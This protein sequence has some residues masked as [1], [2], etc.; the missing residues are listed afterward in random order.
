MELIEPSV[1]YGT[2]Y[3]EALQEYLRT[4]VGDGAP[5]FIEEIGSPSTVEEYIQLRRDHAKGKR[6]PDGWIPN[7]TYWLVD[8]RTFLGEVNLRHELTD[9]LRRIGGHIGYWISPFQRKKGYGKEILK[10]VLE[11]AKA[12]DFKKVLITCDES[13]EASIKIIESNGG[14]FEKNEHVAEGKP[15]K[16]LYW[17]SL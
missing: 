12:R 1:Q 16:H 17:I 6:L 13:N 3:W 14:V 15:K 4:D 9:H 8:S 5:N 10:R 11:K 7:S 2:S